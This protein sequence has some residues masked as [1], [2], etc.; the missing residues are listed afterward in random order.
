[1][2]NARSVGTKFAKSAWGQINDRL[3]STLNVDY[4][5][6]FALSRPR[7]ATPGCKE[8]TDSPRGRRKTAL[9]RFG[10]FAASVPPAPTLRVESGY[11]RSYAQAPL[12]PTNPFV[13]A[14]LAITVS[15]IGGCAVTPSTAEPPD[16][17]WVLGV[18]GNS[19]YRTENG[20]LARVSSQL[21]DGN[22]DSKAV[23]GRHR[24]EVKVRW[25]NDFEEAVALDATLA[26]RRLY[27]VFAFEMSPGADPAKAMVR[28]PTTSEMLGDGAKA[29]VVMTGLIVLA[30][31][32]VAGALITAP[33]SMAADES[34]A[35]TTRPF[36]GCCFVWL[37]DSSSEDIVAGS[38]PWG[39]GQRPG[40]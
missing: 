39:A 26:A 17:V 33:L 21:I 22:P 28:K 9:G 8:L 6:D 19:D 1:V 29:S 32:V 2:L 15:A 37:E 36:A 7:R 24:I 18:S 16:R 11:S 23:A 4:G 13:L 40:S 3:R 38:S 34:P 10:A 20:S 12:R 27:R 25:S 14:T 30:P 5:V 31:V 35:P